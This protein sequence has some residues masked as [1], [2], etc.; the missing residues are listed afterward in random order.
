MLSGHDHNL[1]RHSPQK[2][3][4]QYVVGAGGRGRYELHG[5]RGDTMVWGRDDING[6]LRIVLKPGSALLEFRGP[7]GH[8]LDRSRASCSPGVPAASAQ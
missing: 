6:A 5:S 8:V 3:L 2:G 4:T 1:Q 7:R